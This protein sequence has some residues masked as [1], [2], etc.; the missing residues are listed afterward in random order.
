MGS[1]IRIPTFIFIFGNAAS[2]VRRAGQESRYY[3]GRA[4]SSRALAAGSPRLLAESGRIL[5]I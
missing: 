3:R 5:G 2:T 4:R 1:T